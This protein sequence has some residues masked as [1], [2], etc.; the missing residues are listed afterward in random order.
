MEYE[1]YH[2]GVKGM[3]W[4][5][6]RIKQKMSDAKKLRAKK[7]IADI[8]AKA[9]KEHWSEDAK[10]ATTLK[11]KKVKQLSNSE[12]K[13]LNERIRLENEFANLTKKDV[14]PGVKFTQGILKESGKNIASKYVTE[15][16]KKGIDTVIE[17]AGAKIAAA[18]LSWKLRTTKIK[19]R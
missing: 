11:T 15:Y 17:F 10:T 8:K 6:R 19:S 7:K 3:K 1:L 18:A 2:H 4:G 5:V 13:K 16:G 12:L 9:H 14:P